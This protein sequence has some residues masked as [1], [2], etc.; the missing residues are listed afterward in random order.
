MYGFS[1]GVI[2]V[3]DVGC[4]M[5]VNDVVVCFFDRDVVDFDGMVVVDVL[6]EELMIVLCEG[7]F[8]G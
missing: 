1:E 7:E 2:M 3:D 6:G 8:V 4:I 5:F